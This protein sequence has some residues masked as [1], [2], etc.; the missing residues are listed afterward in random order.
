ML[1][2]G[3]KEFGLFFF[4]KETLKFHNAQN[5]IPGTDLF[6]LNS[7]LD[8]IEDN[9]GLFWVG[10]SHKGISKLIPAPNVFREHVIGRT[11][12]G[13]IEPQEN[14]FWFGTRNGIVILDRY[15][16]LTT[17]MDHDFD[18]PNSL[19]NDL[20]TD[21]FHDGDDI[22]IGTYNGVNRY[23][24][25]SGQFELF[26]PDDA[27]NPIA[28][29][30]VWN[31]M[32]DWRNDIWFCTSNGLSHL[33]SNTGKI[34]NYRN[35]PGNPNSLSNNSCYH[36]QE[37]SPGIYLVSTMYGLNRFNL[38]NNEWEVFLPIPGDLTSISSDYIFGVYKD[39]AE[40][41]WVFTNGGGF[42]RF[43]P[44]TNEF[45]QF[46]VADG[47]SDNV[48]YG[49]IEDDANTLWLSTN[50]GLSHFDPVEERFT[51]FD[52]QDGILRN[53]FNINSLHKTRSGEIFIGGVNGTTSFYP[54]AT[55]G[56]T[57]K[58]PVTFTSFVKY[59]E[60]NPI[61]VPVTSSI[62]LRHNENSFVVDFAALDFLNPFKNTYEYFLENYD[63]DW[64]ILEVGLHQVEYRKLRPGTYTLRVLG[65]NNLGVSDEATLIIKVVAAWWQ[66]LFFKIGVVLLSLLLISLVLYAR[67]SNV[68]RKHSMEKQILTIENELVQSQKFALRS[69]MNPHFIFNALNSIQNFVL[70]NDVDSANY[71]L[72]NFSLMMRRVLEYSQNNFITLHE[73]LDLIELYLKMEKLRFSNKFD[74][75]ITVAPDIDVHLIRIPPMLLQPYLENS[76]LHGLQLIKHKGLLSLMIKSKGDMM[77]III[78]D[79]GIGRDRARQIREK[80][81]HKSK[82]LKNIEKR[83][84]LYNK[85]NIKP[86]TINFEDLI[87]NQNKPL[88][89]RVKLEVPIHNEEF[90]Q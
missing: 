9:R 74:T 65:S 6:N 75:K 37:E 56:S 46:T 18:D 87:D 63:N 47:L 71:Y 79:N 4:N 12:Y 24:Q 41:Y 50:N 32:K 3:T 64:N 22:W 59:V 69:Q 11:I 90:D 82:G 39:M 2:I 81:F 54:M 13:I 8:I 31:I 1:W 85:L 58:P 26:S 70:K 73:E 61:S 27:V 42:N 7:V 23:H 17:S 60:G 35:E 52:V 49:I 76:I 16:N 78:E 48:V 14:I 84:T 67:T 55:V 10:T 77:E 25:S 34:T 19:V 83:I 80:Q 5:Y 57:Q 43:D 72:S 20:V 88:G 86:I 66:T 38:N 44:E 36:I 53:E 30:E 29:K 68:N 15:M 89:T 21:L 51:K 33:K 28:G 62:S 45:E 40:E